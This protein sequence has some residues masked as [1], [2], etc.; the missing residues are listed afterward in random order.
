MRRGI[1]RLEK[2]FTENPVI[3]DRAINKPAEARSAVN[4]TAPVRCPSRAEKDQM[5]KAQQRFRF[6][7]AVLL[8]QESAQRK[9]S[10]MPDDCGWTEGNGPSSLLNSP[11]KTHI[12]AG[13]PIFGIEPAY[14]F[15]C[16]PVKRHVTTGNMLGDSIRKQNMVWAA[17]CRSKARLNPVLCSR[18]NVRPTH[19]GVFAA[20]KR[21]NQTVQ[22][23]GVCHAVGI[24]VGQHFALGGGCPGV[25][26]VT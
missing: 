23:I 24:G 1:D 16:P 3:N 15:E 4:L 20:D 8:I 18:R 10:I 26:R 5:F 14:T 9:P 6:A 17:G 25:A 2:S 11:A 21:A 22:P 13:L 19:S 7:V 12:V